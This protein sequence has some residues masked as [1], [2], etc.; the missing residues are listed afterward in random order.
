MISRLL[1]IGING[2][3][4][5]SVCIE[6][7]TIRGLPGF[8]I[9][10]L[11]DSTVKESRERIRSAIENSGFEFPPRHYI[12]N[13][14]PAGWKKQGSSFD[15]P[16]A[17]AILYISGQLS[18]IPD[19]PVIGELSLDGTVREIDSALA[20]SLF[21]A[22]KKMG[23]IIVPYGNRHEA[24]SIDGINV[25]PVKTL[26]EACA[27]ACGKGTVCTER[28][29]PD[30]N[31]VHTD[32]SD[33]AGQY[34][35]KRALEIA[36]AGFHNVIMYGPPGAGKTMLARSLPSIMPSLDSKQVIETSIIH[37]CSP[38]GSR[39]GLVLNPPFRTPHHSSSA[40]SIIGGGHN[41]GPGEVTLAH[42]GVLFLDELTEFTNFA[43][44]TLRQAMEDGEVTVSRAAGAYRFPSRFMLIGACNPCRCGY[45][46]ED[47]V[48]CSCSL[49]SIA[50]YYTKIAGPLLDRIDIEVYVPGVEHRKLLS[51]NRS[52]SSEII[53]ERVLHARKRQEKRY[54]KK[55]IRYNSQISGSGIRGLCMLDK[56]AENF[57]LEESGRLMSAR[58]F[59]KTVKLARTIADLED[60][61]RVMKQHI[62][63]ALAFN[64]MHR[65]YTSI[66]RL[67]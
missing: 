62:A 5:Y 53:R 18:H 36:A 41:P 34:Q 60:S 49:K 15:L 17:L 42:N 65:R 58:S 46:F 44:Q 24:A 57:M 38:K 55:G 4:P 12:V 51:E 3:E 7:D 37:S 1:S 22:E 31:S 25:Y 66:T 64:N 26:R 48:R 56:E 30:D 39:K 9:V 61:D 13:L 47:S 33:I 28:I 2:I 16:A 52:E 14:A 54:R 20:L 23:G 35:G 19:I 6:V 40:V 63:E 27:A 32:F 11:P 29:G 43:L 10:G 50:S 45:A 8:T 67:Y 21:C 59:F